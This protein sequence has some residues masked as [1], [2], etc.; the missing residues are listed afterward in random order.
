[1]RRPVG[2][3]LDKTEEGL[4]KFDEYLHEKLAHLKE[5]D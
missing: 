5:K 3:G 2:G 1:M 4:W